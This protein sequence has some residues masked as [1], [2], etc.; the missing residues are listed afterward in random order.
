[1][2][3]GQNFLPKFLFVSN[4][5]KAVKIRERVPNDVVKPA[6]SESLM[7]HLRGMH[8]YTLEMISMSQFPQAF[9]QV[10][11]AAIL[12]RAMQSSLEQEK[13]LN[14]CHEVKKMVPLRT[15]GDGNCLLHAASQ[16]MLG[17]QD[18]DLVLRRPCT[19][20]SRRTNRQ[21]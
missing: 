15:N 10:I 4:L 14:W 20:C 2:S 18:T 5:L 3:Q 7:H 13:K 12:D 11:Q 1:M 17:V 9:Q 19:V 8:R 21:L 16:Y 6:G